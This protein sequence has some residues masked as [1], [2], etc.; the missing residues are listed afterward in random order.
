MV[1][2][3]TIPVNSFSSVTFFRH[4]FV[5]VVVVAEIFSSIPPPPCAVLSLCRG[6]GD[7]VLQ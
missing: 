1:P 3:T 5:V 4:N 2:A 6:G 7:C